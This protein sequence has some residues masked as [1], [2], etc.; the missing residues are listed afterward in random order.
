MGES[1]NRVNWE[2]ANPRLEEG[3][4]FLAEWIKGR[5]GDR[6]V[7]DSFSPNTLDSK[8]DE[9]CYR[10]KGNNSVHHHGHHHDHNHYHH[11]RTTFMTR[12]SVHSSIDG[13]RIMAPGH[14]STHPRL[15]V[16]TRV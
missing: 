9:W 4:E 1:R 11:V 7:V 15:P 6:L 5:N 3:A 8:L 13:Y 12:P 16:Q 10:S 14:L 2:G